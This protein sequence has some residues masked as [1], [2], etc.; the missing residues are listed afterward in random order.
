M[1]TVMK[2]VLL[3]LVQRLGPMLVF[4]CEE[5]WQ[6]M[7]KKLKSVFPNLEESVHLSYFTPEDQA[8]LRQAPALKATYSVLRQ[9]RQVATEALGQALA[10][11]KLVPVWELGL[12][13]MRLPRWEQTCLL[14][15]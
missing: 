3:S 10:E 2:V 15:F 4:P 13:S 9:I 6:T 12:Q 1:Q 7:R 5:V 11:K 8:L 14:I